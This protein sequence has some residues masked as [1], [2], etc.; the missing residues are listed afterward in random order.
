MDPLDP[1]LRVALDDEIPPHPRFRTVQRTGA[2]TGEEV[3]KALQYAVATPIDSAESVA[4]A[5]QYAVGIPQDNA[6]SVSKAVQYVIVEAIPPAP[7]RQRAWMVVLGWPNELEVAPRLQWRKMPPPFGNPAPPAAPDRR[8][9]RGLYA[10]GLDALPITWPTPRPPT[11]PPAPTP[12]TTAATAGILAIDPRFL[13]VE[14]WTSEMGWNM[15]PFGTIP[16]MRLGLDWRQWARS[17][18]AL[19]AVLATQPPSPDDFE[20]WERWAEEFNAKVV[21]A[22]YV[23]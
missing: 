7:P 20:T 15:A 18:N 5:L 8:V 3:A 14:R 22:R 19:P 6:E 16:A 2:P 17:V 4:K 9:L 21:L 1:R 13:T 10:V 23:I 11:P 12:T